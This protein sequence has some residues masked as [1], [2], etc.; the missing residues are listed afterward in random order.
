MSKRKAAESSLAGDQAYA[1]ATLPCPRPDCVACK[2]VLPALWRRGTHPDSNLGKT[3]VG[4]SRE[5][6]THSSAVYMLDRLGVDNHSVF[7][8]IGCGHGLVCAA[9][10]EHSRCKKSM[11]IDLATELIAWANDNCPQIASLSYYTGDICEAWPLALDEATH[12]F[13]NNRDFPP[14][15]LCAM[16]HKLY[17]NRMVWRRFASAKSIS[18]ILDALRCCG[19]EE[20]H[21]VYRFWSGRIVYEP[22]LSVGTRLS[23]T[24]CGS[25]QR[26]RIYVMINAG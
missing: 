24:L 3:E 15:V 1:K 6:I 23:V 12:Y 17:H 16:A 14:T 9:A 25:R 7:V 20:Q 18:D 22:F 5:K 13:C 11:G 8:D 10:A 2:V 21:D 26:I 4:P 19:M